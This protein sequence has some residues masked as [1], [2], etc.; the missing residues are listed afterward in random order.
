M[1]ASNIKKNKIYD[2]IIIGGGIAGLYSAYKIKQLYPSLNY[3]I[4]EKSNLINF[5]GRLGNYNFYGQSVVKGAG[6]GRLKKD[7]L[8]KSLLDKFHLDIY[9]FTVSKQYAPNMKK[10][11]CDVG[12]TEKL[13]RKE[14][15]KYKNNKLFNHILLKTFRK[16]AIKILGKESYKK[17]LL[18]TGYRDF[19]NE[20]IEEALFNY[21]FDDTADGEWTG[22][23]VP[24]E[25][26]IKRLGK[27]VG[28]KN[29]K[30]EQEIISVKSA[31][32]SSNNYIITN[33][34]G[35]EYY[36]EKVI[37]AT[38]IDT[39][40]KLFKKNPIYREIVGNVFLRV[41]GKFSGESINIMKE[42]VSKTTIVNTHM[43]KIIPI[44]TDKGIYMI[45]Y[46]DNKNAV[47]YNSY[48]ED[49]SVNRGFWSNELQ[50]ALSLNTF[51]NKFK[52]TL[53]LESI[54]AFYWPIGT[55]YYKPLNP[56]YKTRENFVN[57]AQHPNKNIFIVGE[58]ISRKQGWTEGALESVEKV[59]RANNFY[60]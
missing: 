21:G 59:F 52:K 30:F 37:V 46:C 35:H 17:F 60:K 25:K 22:F 45:S 54:K 48:L 5:G 7:I 34:H 3:I 42:H 15:K 27:E 56:V 23:S 50:K 44:N 53:K 1:E 32:K 57:I 20:D 47:Y 9:K 11:I 31:T 26:L 39:V 41:Y 13:L 18:S 29:I 6:I 8:L 28:M 10:H 36:A 33:I 14:Y 19:E 4:L 12:F 43:Q 2:I 51:K 58:M 16:F 49:T 55:H 24:W 40:Q 38:T